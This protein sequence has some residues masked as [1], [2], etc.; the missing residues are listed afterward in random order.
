MVLVM[1]LLL[2]V[3]ALLVLLLMVMMVMVMVMVSGFL[4]CAHS[5][6]QEERRCNRILPHTFIGRA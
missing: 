4:S 6:G 5:T 3:L 2:L 1:V